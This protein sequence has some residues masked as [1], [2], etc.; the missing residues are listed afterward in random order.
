MFLDSSSKAVSLIGSAAV[1][2]AMIAPTVLKVTPVETPKGKD[3]TAVMVAA[4]QVRDAPERVEARL[5]EDPVEALGLAERERRREIKDRTEPGGN[6]TTSA[7]PPHDRPCASPG[8]SVDVACLRS[9]L[10]L[11][12]EYNAIRRTHIA[13]RVDCDFAAEQARRSLDRRLEKAK[14]DLDAPSAAVV[15]LILVPV[16]PGRSFDAVE[17]RRQTRVALQTAMLSKD[18]SAQRE[19]LIG[20]LAW[21]AQGQANADIPFELFQHASGAIAVVLWLESDRFPDAGSMREL[22]AEFASPA[23]QSPVRWPV[24][25]PMGSWPICEAG[26]QCKRGVS[27]SIVG[28]TGTNGLVVMLSKHPQN[29]ALAALPTLWARLY[30]PASTVDETTIFDVPSLL[31]QIAPERGGAGSELPQQSETP[32]PPQPERRLHCEFARHGLLFIRAVSKDEPVLRALLDEIQRRREAVQPRECAVLIVSEGDSLYARSLAS[33]IELQL[34]R[35]RKAGG[36]R[37]DCR[38]LQV[39]GRDAAGAYQF[40]RSIN[41]P[42]A[43][44]ALEER[45]KARASSG[46]GRDGTGNL[47]TGSRDASSEGNQQFDYIRRLVTRIEKDAGADR[48]DTERVFAVGVFGT[49]PHDKVSILK[50]LKP[51]LPHARFFTTDLDAVLFDADNVTWTRNLIVGTAVGLE[52]GGSARGMPPFRRSQQTSYANAF[53]AALENRLAVDIDT[54]P[55][56]YEI[57]LAGPVQLGEADKTWTL[58]TVVGERWKAVAWTYRLGALLLVAVAVG[59][60]VWFGGG[61]F[62]RL[63]RNYIDVDA[64]GRA[65]AECPFERAGVVLRIGLCTL[66]GLATIAWWVLALASLFESSAGDGEPLVL[67]QG[68][69]LWMPTIV[70]GIAITVG[71]AALVAFLGCVRRTTR[72]TGRNRGLFAWANAVTRGDR[73]TV[74]LDYLGLTR[75]THPPEKPRLWL[76]YTRHTCFTG[77]ASLLIGSGIFL[78]YLGLLTFVHDP[79]VPSRGQAMTTLSELSIWMAGV[80]AFTLAAASWLQTN[81]MKSLV[82]NAIP[83]DQGAC[84]EAPPWPDGPLVEEHLLHPRSRRKEALREWGVSSLASEPLTSADHHRIDNTLILE[85]L[86]RLAR[87]GQVFVYIPLVIASLLILARWRLFENQTFP[88]ALWISTAALIGISL[89]NAWRLS[90]LAHGIQAG[91][92]SSIDADLQAAKREL[93]ASTDADVRKD[94]ERRVRL[95]EALDGRLAMLTSGIFAPLLA[96]PF[97]KALLIPLG[98]GSVL[99]WVAVAKGFG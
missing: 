32:C 77:V 61:W 88:A 26:T 82:H 30:S 75:A 24:S 40:L 81:A 72:E 42:R 97:F 8:L 59:A 14:C 38:L 10:A 93:N 50:L 23:A 36:Q 4:D 12:F 39:P 41:D 22:V 98:T 79:N 85:M 18:W 95:L 35:G 20:W 62:W 78:L 45:D 52:A 73:R 60:A 2:V 29:S 70:R 66:V 65:T 67:F 13:A 44:G 47:I 5:W 64:W 21:K 6:A 83:I 25:E 86:D 27:V 80:L 69:S 19:N 3:S 99:E 34:K 90:T 71:V 7:T 55:Q 17:S 16:Q 53:S 87:P 89:W 9:K 68:V 96:Q 28:P 58:R 31:W 92:R 57:G 11:A 63:L 15:Q 94:L 51:A 84:D 91:M 76:A 74:L 56:L 43:A 49:D 48:L 46:I 37:D 1:I 54:K 33:R